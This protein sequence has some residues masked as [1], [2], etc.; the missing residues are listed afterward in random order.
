MSWAT[1][2]AQWPCNLVHGEANGHD[3]GDG[4]PANAKFGNHDEKDNCHRAGGCNACG[5]LGRYID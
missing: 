5:Q 2:C 1:L 4:M 3:R